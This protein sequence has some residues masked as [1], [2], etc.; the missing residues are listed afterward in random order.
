MF[1][2][3]L[4][5]GDDGVRVEVVEVVFK[6]ENEKIPKSPAYFYKVFRDFLVTRIRFHLYHLY[7]DGGQKLSG[8]NSL[9]SSMFSCLRVLGSILTTRYFVVPFNGCFYANIWA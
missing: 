8:M 3:I 4:E 1:S 7:P 5:G 9:A 2:V 6:E